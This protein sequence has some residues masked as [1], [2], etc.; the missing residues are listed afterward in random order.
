[1]TKVL[2]ATAIVIAILA[3]L[4]CGLIIPAEVA[5]ADS[6]PV[7]LLSGNNQNGE[8]VVTATLRDNE[9]I[10]GMLLTL[11]Y[12]TDKMVLTNC[13]V[14]T[15]LSTLDFMPTNVDTEQGYAAYP[16]SFMWSGDA[17]DS[18]NGLLL[19]MHFKV[20]DGVDGDAHVTFTYTTNQDVNYIDD[21]KELRTRNL[22]VDTL[23]INLSQGEATA[24]TSEKSHLYN[25]SSSSKEQVNKT[26]VTVGLSV[27]VP[28]MV[29][30]I[31]L[32]PFFV[33]RRRNNN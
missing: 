22:I 20:L 13:Q 3:V 8:V 11:E 5:T 33:V 7:L 14:G 28:I 25:K 6:N 30:L 17:N 26:A 19:T 9:G 18:S 16:F 32:V 27:G 10:S 29:A 12:N 1:M 2:R 31:I 15:A 21:K 24:F 23:R 4:L